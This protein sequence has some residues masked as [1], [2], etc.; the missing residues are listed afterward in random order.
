MKICL[1]IAGNG[2]EFDF[3]MEEKIRTGLSYSKF[4]R[5]PVVVGDT[6]YYYIHRPEQ[7]RGFNDVEVLFYGTFYERKNLAE[8]EKQAKIIEFTSKCSKAPTGDDGKG[9]G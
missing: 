6:R 4:G 9:V 8:F 7:M 2:R 3:L 5:S 1:V